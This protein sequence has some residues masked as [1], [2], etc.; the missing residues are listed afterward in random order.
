M[1]PI[2][3]R[4][5]K[6]AFLP[7]LDFFSLMVGCTVVY[8]VRY[9][10]IEAFDSTQVFDVAFS[11]VK[12]ITP[13]E[14]LFFSGVISAT[15]VFLYAFFGLYNLQQRYGLWTTIFRL[16]LGIYITL[17]TLILY[18]FFNEYNRETFPL[19]I[20]ISRFILAIGGFFAFYSVLFFRFF[21][22]LL[23]RFL[24]IMGRAKTNVLLIGK[25]SDVLIQNLKSRIDIQTVFEFDEITPALLQR[26]EQ[27]ILNREITEIYVKNANEEMY[28]QLAYLA[29][30]SKILFYFYPTEIAQYSALGVKS[31]NFGFDVYLE[32]IHTKLDGWLVVLKRM[33]DIA[34]SLIAC[35]IFSPILTVVAILIKLEDGGPIFYLSDRVGP[36]GNAFKLFKFRRLKADLCTDEKNPAS[37]KALEFEETLIKQHD[38]R[39]DGVLYKIQD[40]PRSTRIGKFIE[41]TSIDELPQFLNV[42][43][44]NMSV[45]GPRPHQPREVKKYKKHHYKVLNIKPGI[46]GMA[47]INGRSDLNFDQE[48][49]LDVY[50]LENWSLWMDIV[51]ILKTPFVIFFGRHKG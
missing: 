42:L 30:R 44:G 25:H 6:T 20:P 13:L 5:W 9:R 1:L 16:F 24:Y 47:Q 41:K 23:R 48:V 17:S 40:D 10:W 39:K 4:V 46:T 38:L 43:L 37:K 3:R 18:F 32:V 15:I 8:L 12:N 14:Y 2:T 7:L 35:V 19:G 51:I 27:K 21:F 49:A 11:Q 36:D 31:V 33:L 28:T 29:E 45:V 22:W 26:I 50:Y 34:V